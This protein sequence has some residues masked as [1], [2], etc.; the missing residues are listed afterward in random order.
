METKYIY[1][2]IFTHRR[3][4]SNVAKHTAIFVMGASVNTHYSP[5]STVLI[6]WCSFIEILHK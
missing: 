6:N 1:D 2:V 4:L 5:E 3:L